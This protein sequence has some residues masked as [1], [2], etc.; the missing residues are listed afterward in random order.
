MVMRIVNKCAQ[1]ACVRNGGADTMTLVK[2]A[3]M[4]LVPIFVTYYDVGAHIC[5]IL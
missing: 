3:W 1:E 2:L 4:T 5:D